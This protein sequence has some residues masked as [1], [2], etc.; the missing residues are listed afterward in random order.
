MEYRGG[1]QM[2]TINTGANS[3]LWRGSLP[4][5]AADPKPQHAS[6]YG[7]FAPRGNV[8]AVVDR[9]EDAERAV[10][11]TRLL[12]LDPDGVCIMPARAAAAEAWALEWS[13]KGSF[14]RFVAS[15]VRTLSQEDEQQEAYL[16]AARHGA[17]VVVINAR[18]W[19]EVQGA[20]S[21][22]LA[23]RAHD[24]AYYSGHGSVETFD[25]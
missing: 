8:V 15:V 19:S 17:W 18:A 22:L 2:V 13:T 1:K 24:L 9:R 5:D 21:A 7:T 3:G 14:K 20:C 6:G 4:T 11:A 23:H 25:S 10:A 12:G 16:A